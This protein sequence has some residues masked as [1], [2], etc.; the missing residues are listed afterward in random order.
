VTAQI[1]HAPELRSTL[2]ADVSWRGFPPAFPMLVF[3]F[4]MYKIK[5]MYL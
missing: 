4:F 1:L 5:H 2:A 3:L